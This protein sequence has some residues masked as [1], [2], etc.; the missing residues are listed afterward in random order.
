[1]PRILVRRLVRSMQEGADKSMQGDLTTEEQA[2]DPTIAE[3]ARRDPGGVEGA[4][5]MM[6]GVAGRVLWS[7]SASRRRSRWALRERQ[8]EGSWFRQIRDGADTISGTA[9]RILR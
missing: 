7:L 1:M 4:A 8:L 9:M 3:V 2:V 6:D 5:S